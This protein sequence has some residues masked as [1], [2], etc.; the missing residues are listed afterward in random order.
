[1]GGRDQ[2][3][4]WNLETE[5]PL[6]KHEEAL[7]QFRVAFAPKGTHLIIGKHAS[8]PF[9]PGNNGGTAELWDF[10][11]GE[12]IRRFPE[13]GGCIALSLRGDRLATGNWLQTIKIW[14]FASGQLVRSLE[15]GGD[16]IALALSPDGQTLATSYWDAEV[17][18]WDVINGLP[19]GSLTN[20]Q[21]RV[22]NMVFS[23]KGRSLATGGA[24][25]MVCLWDVATC[26]QTEAL[27][28]HGGEVMSVAFAADG[29]TL[30]SGSRD[31]KAMLWSVH[32]SRAVTT[33]SNTISRAIFSPDSHLVAAGIGGNKVEI[34]DVSTLE[35]KAVFTDAHDALAFTPDGS[36][37][38]TQG[39]NY[40]LR[41]FNVATQ[42]VR[43]TIPGRPAGDTF[44]Y[45]V[46]SP[47]EQILATG[48]TNGT[49]KFSDAKTGAVR[50]TREHAYAQSF[51]KMA[52]SPNGKLLATA[53]QL[54]ESQEPAA[55]IWDAATAN[56]V[57]AP[58]G[59][60]FLVIDVAFTPDGKTLLTCGGDASIKFW[61]TTTWKE[62]P[63]SLGQ[64]EFVSAL[65]LSP[66]G[67][68]LATACSDGRMQLWN[69]VTRHEVA[70]LK[71]LA[72]FYITFSPDGQTLVA[73]GDGLLSVWRAP[74]LSNKK[75]SRP[76]DG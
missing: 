56:R 65:A 68:R 71:L 46:L 26:H 43:E 63:P 38:I 18:L 44:F 60:T 45:D 74:V 24:D 61:D 30:A 9:S 57:A 37:L 13:S 34:W 4:V 6:F 5:L 42:T 73:Q 52:F 21:H 7:G 31:K 48:L 12:L 54:S 70:S 53:G 67:T 16:V 62:I 35:E 11:T 76:P 2:V 14:D 69:V 47:D 49:L 20:Q 22:W 17:K 19:V 39:T 66:N 33:V 55:Q 27:Q 50:A 23:P 25:Q 32:P 3:V 10:A 40:F 29:Q 15:T 1:V 41:T 8:P 36:G 58:L 59:H 51:F 64:K 28:G 75:Q 72:G